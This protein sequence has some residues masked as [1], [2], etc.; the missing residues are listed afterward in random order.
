MGSANCGLVQ[1]NKYSH[2]S[3]SIHLECIHTP[4]LQVGK[5]FL[6]IAAGYGRVDIMNLL[7]QRGAHVDYPNE[8]KQLVFFE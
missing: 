5:S 7:F 2:R 6:S 3:K 1:V 8:V 4:P